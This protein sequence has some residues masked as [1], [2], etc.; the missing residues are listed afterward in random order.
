MLDIHVVSHTHWDREWYLTHEQFRFRL[1]ALID[2]LLDLLDADPSYKHFHLDGQTIVLEDYLEIRP[3]QEPRLRRAIDEGRILVGPWYVMPDEFLVSG[4]S[5]VRNLLRG[6]RISRQFGSPMPVGYLPDLFGHVGQMPQIWRQFGLDNTILWRGFGG[7]DAE[8]WW[9]AP[10]GSRVLMMHL[11]P[12]GYCN[13]TRIVFDPEAM[14][15]RAAEKVGYERARTRTGQALLMNGVDHVEPHT[16][17]P[18]L[19]DRLSSVA[20]QKATH[21]TLP[22]YVDAVRR[23][24]ERDRPPLET[25]TG[26]L[27]SGTDYANL[28]PGVLS[29]RV[30][31]KQQNAQVQ[32]LLESYAEPLSVFASQLGARYPAGELRYAWKTLLQNHPHDSIC[33]CSIDAVHEENMTRFAR[34]RQVGSAVA[35]AA[36]D[37]I[38]DSVPAPPAGVV[39]AV[40]V[41]PDAIE[42]AQVV[43]AFVDLPID[44]AEPWRS[45][46][47]QALDRPVVFWP[48]EAA[49]EEV[50]GPDGE[51]VEFQVLG[52]ERLVNHVMSR[53][54][55]PWALNVRR[56]HVLLWAQALPPCG[57][58]AFDLRIVTP[59]AGAAKAAPSDPSRAASYSSAYGR[60]LVT[61]GERKAENERLRVSV[62]DDGTF[63]VMD[64][65]SGVAYSQVA[66][67]EDVGDVGDEYNYC[68]PA[69]DGR[70]TNLDARV[71][72]IAR[73]AAGP[74]R[75]SLRVDLELPLPAAASADRRRRADES[76]RVPVTIEAVLDA[77]SPRVG[78]TVT[79]DNR[80]SDHRLRVLFPCGA[81]R[82]PTARADT[83][84]D[85]VTRPARQEVPAAIK[86]ESPVSSAPMIS[87]VD[88]GDDEVGATVFGKGLMEYEIVGEPPAIALTLLRAVGDLS[89][90]DLATRPSG[91]AGPPVAT[92]AAQC[93][94]RHVFEMAFEPRGYPPAAAE[95]VTS[96]RAYVIAPRVATAMKPGGSGPARRSFIAVDRTA[97]GVVLSALKQAEDR[98]SIVVRLFNPDNDEARATV[99]MDAPIAEAFAVNLLE[100]R[101]AP[102]AVD[103]GAVALRLGPHQIQT[104][105]IV[106]A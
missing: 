23:A 5:L 99:R 60:R 24:V 80:A 55:T 90:N 59:A 45:V 39:R 89:R 4:E 35:D 37:A 21:S 41:N 43:E 6:H 101:Q 88:A 67:L 97:G 27:R 63:Q 49:I 29:A 61:A 22:A 66:S 83:A 34:A 50:T 13:A 53:Y 28:L 79:V 81:E 91:H 92:P 51:R 104:I 69:A 70:V 17:I 100:E 46:D 42:R 84:F 76:V 78:F 74:L 8:Y 9:D 40:V 15:A 72:G 98:N 20:D 57:Y 14:M 75:A 102:L 12:E 7:K 38:A 93:I 105:E 62:N 18:L 16:A 48:I 36:L 71:T 94:G 64:K 87:L 44:S 2:R 65:A 106:H 10:D 82:V 95:L 31:L 85:V 32:T 47:A 30:Y 73:G 77:G 33:G 68:P 25:V 96:A 19:I 11:P 26:E 1:V 3:E 103:N 58:A 52:E 56:L 86:N 54:E